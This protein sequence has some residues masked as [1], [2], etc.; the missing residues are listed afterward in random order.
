MT[1]E[2]AIDILKWDIN[3]GDGQIKD[4]VNMGIKALEQESIMLAQIEYLQKCI[5]E[6]KREVN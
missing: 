2:E 1:R 4:A 5:N 6:L 3:Y